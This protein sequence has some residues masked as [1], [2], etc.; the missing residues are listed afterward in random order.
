MSTVDVE[1]GEIFEPKEEETAEARGVAVEVIPGTRLGRFLEDGE[2]FD[3]DNTGYYQ[4]TLDAKVFSAF[5]PEHL[6]AVKLTKGAAKMAL[7]TFG[8]RLSGEKLERG[9]EVL[10]LARYYAKD[11]HVPAQSEEG[12]ITEGNGMVELELLDIRRLEV[13][14]QLLQERSPW[15]PCSCLLPYDRETDGDWIANRNILEYPLD[16]FS[17]DQHCTTCGG[18]GYFRVTVKPG[19]DVEDGE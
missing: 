14:R 2:P 15:K 6:V 12:F 19:E 9:R 16:G 8:K 1:T 5:T 18:L 7:G 4:P 3:P 13:G 10:V 11:V 17:A